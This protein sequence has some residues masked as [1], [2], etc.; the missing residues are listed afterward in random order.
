M[1]AKIKVISPNGFIVEFETPEVENRLKLMEILPRFETELIEA[2]Y[3][4]VV[5]WRQ[6]LP[7]ES[8]APPS[9]SFAVDKITAT[10]DDGKVYWRVKGG[11]FQKFGVVVY[12]EV[13]EAAGLGGINPVQP[14][15]EPGMVAYYSTKD[16]GKPKKITRIERVK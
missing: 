11:E 4:P 2:G 14:F 15:S 12:P 1:K 3:E 8:A 13:L 6:P 7:A 16:N 10:I 9:T 5:A